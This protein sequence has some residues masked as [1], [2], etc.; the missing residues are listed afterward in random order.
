MQI[1]GSLDFLIQV[2]TES[3]L[4]GNR[5]EI[6]EKRMKLVREKESEKKA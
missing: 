2:I 3:L 1:L 5:G 4:L 6:Q